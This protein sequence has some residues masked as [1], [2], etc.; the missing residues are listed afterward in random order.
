MATRLAKFLFLSLLSLT[1]L[2]CQTSLLSQYNQVRTGMEKDDVI[3]L[4]GSPQRTERMRDKDRWTYIFYDKRV[5]YEKE[6]QFT[7]GNVVYVGEPWQIAPEKSAEVIDKKNAEAEQ[8]IEEEKAQKNAQAKASYVNVDSIIKGDVDE[9]GN[10]KV[11]YLPAFE[12]L[13]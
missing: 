5:R 2:A 1:T 7:K 12:E 4:M 13:K 6:I 9:K 3:D 10:S 11:R 8:K